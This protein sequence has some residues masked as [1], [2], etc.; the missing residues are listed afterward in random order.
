MIENWIVFHHMFGQIYVPS[1]Y[2]YIIPLLF[3]LLTIIIHRL[4]ID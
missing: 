4:I 3:Q 2:L 1:G